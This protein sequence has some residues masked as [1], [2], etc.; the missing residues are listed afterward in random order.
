MEAAPIR[1]AGSRSARKAV[2]PK[3]EVCAG[4]RSEKQTLRM[5]H[6][7]LDPIV[8]SHQDTILRPPQMRDAY[9]EPDADGEERQGKSEGRHIRQHA[10]SII[11]ALI[12]A[13]PLVVGEIPRD[14]KLAD[15]LRATALGDGSARPRPKLEHAVLHIWRGR[16]DRPLGSHGNTRSGT[17][18]RFVACSCCI[19]Q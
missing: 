6:G 18:R 2:W 5:R 14:L 13:I 17:V 7:N 8:T 10:L 15:R 9:R 11:V 16:N 4:S 3:P 1:L 12:L 19:S